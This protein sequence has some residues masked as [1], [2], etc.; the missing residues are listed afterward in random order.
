MKF[1]KIVQKMKR[2]WRNL[3]S[4]RDIEKF[5][6]TPTSHHHNN[7]L[8]KTIHLLVTSGVLVSIRK[9][10]YLSGTSETSEP[11]DTQDFYWDI[12]RKVLAENYASQGII[13]GQK[14]LALTL[15]D[16]SLPEVLSV[17]VP[18]KP[19]KITLIEW[20]MMNTISP[21][22]EKLS[23]YGTLKKY[24]TKMIIDDISLWVTCPEHALLE[25]LTIRN[26][27]NTYD[28]HVILR[29]LK[30]NSHTLRMEVFAALVPQK[31]I[32]ATNRLKYLAYDNKYMELY[33]MM[34]KVIDLHWGG[35]HL[36]REFLERWK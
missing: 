11:L 2:K 29:W 13:V 1:E 26:G 36:S 10:L 30:K 17:C 23:L 35:C 25:T 14:A 22:S 31:Y 9:W 16:Y 18:R 19:K 12:V 34:I 20:Y 27:S 4:V 8:Y 33:M 7:A 24:A 15:K 21:Q 5:I 6:V 28:T 3:W 32:S